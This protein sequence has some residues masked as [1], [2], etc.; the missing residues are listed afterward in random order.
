M[1]A[2]ERDSKG[3][4]PILRKGMHPHK[5]PARVLS[6][7]LAV[8]MILS[9]MPAASAQTVKA[10]DT[11]SYDLETYASKHNGSVT[12]T[13]TDSDGNKPEIATEDTYDSEGNYVPA[14]GY[15]ID[16]TDFSF[17]LT[18]Y[19]GDGM[20]AGTYTYSLPAGV[21]LKGYTSGMI[22]SGT[23]KIVSYT[24]SDGVI[25]FTADEDDYS[26][27]SG[28]AVSF[29]II[30]YVEQNHYADEGG[31][32]SSS[33]S[34]SSSSD[35]LR[36]EKTWTIDPTTMNYEFTVAVTLPAYTSGTY[37]VYKLYDEAGYYNIGGDT[38]AWTQ[39][40][41]TNT[42]E[43]FTA[44]AMWKKTD[45]EGNT[46]TDDEGSP[47]YVYGEMFSVL[48][49][50]EVEEA[51]DYD[52]DIA[53]YIYLNSNDRYMM[54][55]LNKCECGDG[56]HEGEDEDDFVFEINGETWCSNWSQTCV[57]HM[58]I[59]YEEQYS[60]II[61]TEYSGEYYY[62]AD[63]DYDYDDYNNSVTLYYGTGIVDYKRSPCDISIPDL[64]QSD[65]DED[66]EWGIFTYSY[67]LNGG[68]VDA[69]GYTAYID[70][71]EYGSA[72]GE[73]Y[74]FIDNT[75]SGAA[76]IPGTFMVYYYEDNA[77]EDEDET[78]TEENRVYL[79]YGTDYEIVYEYYE[80]LDES[81]KAIIDDD[82]TIYDI[83]G[84]HLI[85]RLNTES[86]GAYTYYLVYDTQICGSVLENSG[87][88]KSYSVLYLPGENEYDDEYEY[89]YPYTYS[90]DDYSYD[91]YMELFSDSS[92]EDEGETEDGSEDEGNEVVPVEDEAQAEVIDIETVAVSVS[93]D[94]AESETDTSDAAQSSTAEDSDT[95]KD[96]AEDGS[97][98]DADTDAS[99]DSADTADASEDSD[100][101]SD[102]SADDTEDAE[103]EE[104]E[105][106]YL[107]Y[108]E[109]APQVYASLRNPQG[110]S[111]GP[112][113]GS[114]GSASS[115]GSD[116]GDFEA[117]MLILTKV[118]EKTKEVITTGASYDLYG[119]NGEYITSGTTGDD[120]TV[121]FTI[122]RSKGI[123][124]LP[125]YLYYFVETEAPDGYELDTSEHW[126]CMTTSSDDDSTTDSD[127]DSTASSDEDSDYISYL[128]ATTITNSEGVVE[129][130]YAFYITMSDTPSP[131][132]ALP[133]TGADLF[134]SRAGMMLGGG[135]MAACAV[136][137]Y[138]C[139]TR[140]KKLKP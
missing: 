99:E 14:G 79:T 91:A 73:E 37:P 78:A 124:I 69:D 98:E 84:T 61:F 96:N 36:L 25:T 83:E 28:Y 42:L 114:D 44:Q 50:E 52:Q 120:G 66:D 27:E 94:G 45:D 12:F 88:P 117:L 33:S 31:D 18:V 9:L 59:V 131:Y 74:I 49:I 41:D 32:T 82:A 90:Y 103:S 77:V 72:Y 132:Y 11:S 26:V 3:G 75:L 64:I 62:L 105:S 138:C 87:S 40:F 85:I 54:A 115:G 46:V 93:A 134:G 58:S 89:G 5:R 67:T 81:G 110:S 22:Y 34:S 47:V 13:I 130:D 126:F 16:S 125:G 60:H 139:Y 19:I 106:G 92:E 7:I 128:V 111:M 6:V 23:N 121:S 1:N 29:K 95:N 97:A 102:E 38:F 55:F 24:I 122:Q 70:L 80:Y 2:K 20:E 39:D 112:G 100:D 10:D 107:E 35:E 109:T 136:G 57:Y 8:C 17:T 21:E 119:E 48:S 63:D 129:N 123:V 51:E 104:E 15:I 113:A 4:K 116:L 71:S 137:M 30:R 101:D 43:E 86:L 135:L 108:S 140:R 56:A 127:E 65:C 76:Y 133:S 68:Y 118:D 53:Y